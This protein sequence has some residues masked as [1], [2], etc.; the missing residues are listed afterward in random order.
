MSWPVVPISSPSTARRITS[1]RII[2]ARQGML[3]MPER[4]PR[5]RRHGGQGMARQGR[6]EDLVHR[7][8]IALGE[9][10]QREL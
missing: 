6:R 4:G 9:R 5:V 7:A 2:L 8:G 3:C 1:D 10:I